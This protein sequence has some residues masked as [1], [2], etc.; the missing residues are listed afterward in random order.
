[1]KISTSALYAG[2]LLAFA[3]NTLAYFSCNLTSPYPYFRNPEWKCYVC[4]EYLIGSAPIGCQPQNATVRTLSFAS[5]YQY[6]KTF[7]EAD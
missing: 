4:G 6:T 7:S 2:I 3:Q 1:M 5:S